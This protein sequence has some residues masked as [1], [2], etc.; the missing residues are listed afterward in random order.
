MAVNKLHLDINAKTFKIPDW[1][2]NL[3]F[4]LLGRIKSLDLLAQSYHAREGEVAE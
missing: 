3:F 4:K 1:Y 2:R